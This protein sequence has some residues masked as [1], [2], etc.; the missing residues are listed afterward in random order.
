MNA[1]NPQ[2]NVIAAL[3]SIPLKAHH[4]LEMNENTIFKSN[5]SLRRGIISYSGSQIGEFIQING[6]EKK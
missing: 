4:G 5:E 6:R 2:S 1:F 3:A